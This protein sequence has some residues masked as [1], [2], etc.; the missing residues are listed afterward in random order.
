MFQFFKTAITEQDL[1]KCKHRE[2]CVAI[3][4]MVRLPIVK[5]NAS[6]FEYELDPFW[7]HADQILAAVPA[8]DGFSQSLFEYRLNVIKEAEQIR[9]AQIPCIGT[10]DPGKRIPQCIID[11]MF[12][13]QQET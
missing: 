9:N 1:C 5:R 6:V 4:C 3:F 2:T 8:R 12:R 11:G 7:I 10:A 13:P